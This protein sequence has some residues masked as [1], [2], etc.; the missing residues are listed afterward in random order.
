MIY[1]RPKKLYYVTLTKVVHDNDGCRNF[2]ATPLL[3]QARHYAKKLKHKYRQIDV[4]ERGK[5][6]YVLKGSWL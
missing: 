5:K 6:P 2:I 1:C 4:R 3:S